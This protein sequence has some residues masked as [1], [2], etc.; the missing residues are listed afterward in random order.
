MPGHTLNGCVERFG[1]HI[2][3]VRN[4]GVREGVVALPGP[5]KTCYL[6]PASR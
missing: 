4:G 1:G 6:S 3:Y 2:G 5:Q